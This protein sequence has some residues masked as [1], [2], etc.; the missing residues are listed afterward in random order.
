M[1]KRRWSKSRGRSGS[2]QHQSPS[3]AYPSQCQS[4]SPSPPRSSPVDEQLHHSLENLCLQ[5]RSL[6]SRSRTQQ[7]DASLNAE[8]KLKKQVWFKMDEGLGDELNLPIDI[9]LFFAEGMAPQQSST[10]NSPS[11]LP[12]PTKSH[13]HSHVLTGGPSYG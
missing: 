7:C 10:P 11:K 6:E 12:T 8:E 3:P 9:T 5:P 1:S 13:Q 4:P 2:R